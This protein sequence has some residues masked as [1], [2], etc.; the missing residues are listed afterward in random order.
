LLGL[1]LAAVL[2]ILQ[3]MSANFQL[4][5]PRHNCVKDS[6]IAAVSTVTACCCAAAA[7]V[8]AAPARSMMLTR[9]SLLLPAS[10]LHNVTLNIRLQQQ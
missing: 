4:I 2:N 9:V 3:V 6:D 7:A 1:K 5:I 8:A 10:V